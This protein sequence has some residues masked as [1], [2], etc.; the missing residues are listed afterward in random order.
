MAKSTTFAPSEG[1]DPPN[2]V[3]SSKHKSA[4]VAPG[5]KIRRHS[6]LKKVK[7]KVKN[8]MK[9]DDYGARLGASDDE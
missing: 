8:I 6:I 4:K 7:S 9:F 2:S 5:K 3:K 1:L